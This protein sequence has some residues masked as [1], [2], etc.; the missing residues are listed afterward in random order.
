MRILFVY[1]EDMVLLQYLDTYTCDT[2]LGITEPL[3]M[4]NYGSSSPSLMY[5]LLLPAWEGEETVI[6]V[7]GLTLGVTREKKRKHKHWRQKER[8]VKVKY[9]IQWWWLLVLWKL[10]ANVMQYT[11]KLIYEMV[12]MYICNIYIYIWFHPKRL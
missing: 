3:R 12:F 9:T 10:Y 8:E 5:G 6:I 1:D 7:N 4:W 11:V 2:L